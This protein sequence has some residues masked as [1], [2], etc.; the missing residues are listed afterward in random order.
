[1]ANINSLEWRLFSFHELTTS[2]LYDLM[3][4]RQEVFVVEQN[5][6]YLDADGFDQVAWHVMGCV[7]NQCVAYCRLIGPNIKYADPSIGRVV[8]APAWRRVG[9]GK[10]LMATAIQYSQRLWP[11]TGIRISAQLYL[12]KFYQN[13]GF[14]SVSEP[15]E[16]DGIL[17][18]EMVKAPGLD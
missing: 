1:M 14:E 16:E 18:I 17:H 5:C 12:E 11:N 13:F 4:L 10:L 6:I 9:A 3:R 2:L 15:Y 8:T 7:E